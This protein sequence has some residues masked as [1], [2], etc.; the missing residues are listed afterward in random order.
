MHHFGFNGQHQSQSWNSP[1]DLSDSLTHIECPS[2]PHGP[3][4]VKQ[5][6]VFALFDV[7]GWTDGKEESTKL[8]LP[9]ELSLF[10][11]ACTRTYYLFGQFDRTEFRESCIRVPHSAPLFKSFFY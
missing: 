4:H 1:D 7:F 9:V 11:F 2:F 6:G 10:N 3:V 8:A 5:K